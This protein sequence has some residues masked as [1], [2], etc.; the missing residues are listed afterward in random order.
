MFF[1]N[2]WRQ[3]RL[4]KKLHKDSSWGV[5]TGRCMLAWQGQCSRGET[6]TWAHGEEDRVSVERCFCAADRLYSN[7]SFGSADLFEERLKQA[8]SKSE[9][10]MCR[11]LSHGRQGSACPACASRR[12]QAW[13]GFFS[14]RR[15]QL[16]L[17]A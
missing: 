14:E 16:R 11:G 10:A 5:Y 13:L 1:D 8:K 7:R 2:H 3:L 17:L 9:V 6:C 4:F 12:G 15:P